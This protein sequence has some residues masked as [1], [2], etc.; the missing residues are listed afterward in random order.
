MTKRESVPS[1]DGAAVVAAVRDWVG[2]QYDEVTGLDGVRVDTDDGWFLV[3]A[4]GTEPLVRLTA[5][6][7]TE[8]RAAELLAEATAL[9]DGAS[10]VQTESSECSTA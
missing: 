10:S 1:E 5:E 7:R 3:R 9:L 8:Q 2:D 6:A 4:S